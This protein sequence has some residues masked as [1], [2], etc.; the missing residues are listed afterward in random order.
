MLVT[1]VRQLQMA[2]GCLLVSAVALAQAVDPVV[3]MV[4]NACPP[5]LEQ[6]QALR[7]L[8]AE[9]FF[10]PH[11]IVP[12]DFARLGANP[13][14]AALNEANRQ[15]AAQDW[16][17]VCRYR[18]ANEAA[19]AAAQKPRVVFMGD[20]I[21]E[22]WAAADPRLFAGGVVGRGIGGQTTPQMLLRFRSD[23]VALR[24]AIVHILAGTN[25]V[26]GNT[27]PTT[28]Q[29]FKNNVMSMVE[30]AKAN[31][32]AVIL[33]SIPP[34]AAFPWRP[35]IDPRRDIAELNSWLKDYA[36][37]TGVEFIDYYAALAGSSGELRA[38]LGNDGVHPNYKG[39]AIMRALV[40]RS[41]GLGEGQR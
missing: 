5:P 2:L 9:I 39:Y 15:R 34:A 41:L 22:N 28:Q 27:G 14:L 13:D 7:D 23:V 30:I 20:S 17:S 37:R 36:A 3:G 11:E 25:D 19:L 21:T 4:D 16:A 26:A 40:E 12:A 18:A 8:L 35:E 38:D 32:I 1:V 31:G 29:D 10:E 33:G 6:P 24:P